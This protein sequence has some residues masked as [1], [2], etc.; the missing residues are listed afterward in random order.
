MTQID[1]H[2]SK[3]DCDDLFMNDLIYGCG[4]PFKVNDKLEAEVCDYI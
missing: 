2:L 3:K 1:P 4:R